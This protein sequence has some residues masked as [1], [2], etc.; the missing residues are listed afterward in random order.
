L[1]KN[2]KNDRGSAI[3]E[4]AIILPVILAITLALAGTSQET[5]PLSVSVGGENMSPPMQSRIG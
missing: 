2:L 5:P 3:V 4:V 1:V